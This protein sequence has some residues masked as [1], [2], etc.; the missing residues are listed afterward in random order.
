[1]NY[2][3]RRLWLGLIAEHNA[4]RLKV[5]GFYTVATYETLCAWCRHIGSDSD[6]DEYRM[7]EYPVC[8]HPLESVRDTC[9]D[10]FWS[11]RSDRDCWGF[12]PMFRLTE[13]WGALPAMVGREWPSWQK[14]KSRGC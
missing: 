11:G 13:A 7:Y 10:D 8:G 9:G 5:E 3:K 14:E 12:R 4:Q 1:V 2:F 6:G